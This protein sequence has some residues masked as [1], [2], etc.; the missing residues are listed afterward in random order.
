LRTSRAVAVPYLLAI[1]MAAGCA[2][3]LVLTP[4][5]P[6]IN[7]PITLSGDVVLLLLIAGFCLAELGLVHVEFRRQAYSYALAGLPLAMGLAFC[8]PRQVVGARIVGSL[9]AFLIQRPAAVKIVYNVTAYAFEAALDGFLLHLAWGTGHH[10]DLPHSL[11]L[12]ATVAA[13][14]LLI[15]CLVLVV[16]KSQGATVD[17]TQIQSV[18]LPALAFSLTSTT[19]AL[20]SLITL[21]HGWLGVTLLSLSAVMAGVGHYSYQMLHRRHQALALVH[22]FVEHSKAADNLDELAA[23]L[24]TRTR[25]LLAAARTEVAVFGDNEIF[26]LGVGED[27]VLQTMPVAAGSPDWLLRRVLEQDEAILVKARTRDDGLRRWLH[28][29]AATEAM[30]VP[31]PLSEESRRGLLI[32]F[33]RLGEAQ[34]FTAE[35]LTLLQTLAGHMSV[36]LQNTQ[37]VQRLRHEATHDVLTGLANRALLADNLDHAL[38]APGRS[39]V[40]MLD[41]DRFKEVND[42][43]GHPVGDELLKVIAS[44]LTE[45]LPP[46]ATVARLGGDEFAILV[47]AADAYVE[48]R[49]LRLADQLLSVIGEPIELPDATLVTQA[50]LGI[51]IAATGETAADVLRH[52]DTAMYAA[53]NTHNRVVLY[54]AELDRGRAEKLALLAD[55]QIALTRGELEMHYQPQLALDTGRITGVEALVRWQHPRLGL[56][57]PDAFIPIAESGG[58]IDKLTLIVLEQAT[59]QCQ[60]WRDMGLDLSVAVNLSARNVTSPLICA[61]VTEALA[62]SVLPPDRLIL[63]IT[64]SSIMGD[65]AQTVPALNSL[66]ALGVSLSL[67]DFGTGYSSLAYLQRLPVKEIKI[68][69]SFVLGLAEPDGAHASEVLI[70][71]IIALGKSL[72]LTVVAEGVEDEATLQ[73]LPR[74]GCNLAQGYHISRP[75]PPA[76]LIP[77]LLAGS[78]KLSTRHLTALA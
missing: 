35:D 34:S 45:L 65:P 77:H 12:A 24:L 16:I 28:T 50:S 57:G 52:A 70:R 39:A 27:D 11:A 25:R 6:F 37:L 61:A 23:R 1:A 5:R 29:H 31:L 7:Q 76:E 63:E 9:I 20:M 71:S 73:L 78:T 47:P 68:D 17:R 72:E 64:E 53:K 26:W 75:Q 59:T 2:A 41:L 58:L 36:A 42:A 30:V 49:I 56:L 40:M 8:G 55:L 66:I 43:L 74:L 44:R 51:A 15:G 62:H 10:L 18:L 14:D 48:T 46:D 13:V 54:S 4:N 33:D 60:Q 21:M 32:V 19:L 3:L 22:D 67:D 69:R 38:A